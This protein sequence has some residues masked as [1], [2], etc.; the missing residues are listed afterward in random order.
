MN[1]GS[2]NINVRAKASV[3]HFALSVFVAGLSAILV[4]ALWYPY[5]YSDISGGRELFVLLIAVDV[6]IGPLVTFVVYNKQKPLAELRRDLVV[7]ALLQT[8]ALGYGLWTVAKAR[9]VHIV[10]EIDS[11][12]VVQS[13]D[14]PEE[15]L[16]KAPKNIT[17]F[18]L[19]GPTLIG[20]RPFR[21]EQ[22]K[23]E[24]TLAALG[25][26]HL[27]ARPELW[28]DYDDSRKAVIA[29]AKPIRNLLQR[30]PEYA[31]VIQDV[32]TGR[33]ISDDGLMYLPLVGR[34]S[35]WTVLVDGKTA[36]IL[37]FIPLDSF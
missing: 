18:P 20:L 31:K 16:S 23:F 21:N 25:G 26:I 11:F 8:L 27:S 37:G 19:T 29:A 13:I 35:V 32:V 10:F 14:I 12:R 30:Y 28:Q 17:A 7:V 2:V 34:K 5:P 4:F 9:P 6:I 3:I 1:T 15:L 22:E 24:M 33:S 36:N